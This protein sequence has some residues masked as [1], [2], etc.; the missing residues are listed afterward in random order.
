MDR[1]RGRGIPERVRRRRCHLRRATFRVSWYWRRS[2]S[3]VPGKPRIGRPWLSSTRAT[4]TSLSPVLRLKHIRRH[5][6]SHSRTGKHRGSWSFSGAPPQAGHNR[7]E[8]RSS[9]A[10]YC[11]ARGPSVNRR[12]GQAALWKLVMPRRPLVQ[13]GKCGA[14]RDPGTDR[15]PY[16]GAHARTGALCPCHR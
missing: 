3:P 8:P 15:H 5:S 4:L 14:P 7:E 12:G 9:I 16:D 11:A 2:P 13:S 10:R 1:V 6:M